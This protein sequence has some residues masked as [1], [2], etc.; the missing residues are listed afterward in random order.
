M[1]YKCLTRNIEKKIK[2]FKFIRE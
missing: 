1:G 2:N